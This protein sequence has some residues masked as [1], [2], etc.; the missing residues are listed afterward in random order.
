ML[1]SLVDDLFFPFTWPS[2]LTDWLE[3]L[4]MPPQMASA[5]NIQRI[6][7]LLKSKL[8]FTI[9][10]CLIKC[11]SMLKIYSINEQIKTHSISCWGQQTLFFC[12]RNF[13]PKTVKR[14]PSVV[15]IAS[16]LMTWQLKLWTLKIRE[17]MKL[18][19]ANCENKIS[20][21]RRRKLFVPTVLTPFTVR[22]LID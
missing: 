3:K 7:T 16:N 15:V 17:D 1:K 6:W 13:S 9:Q 11:R 19:V 22:D 8:P 14:Q 4:L 18:I 10:A 12:F 5:R 2:P 21:R 20:M